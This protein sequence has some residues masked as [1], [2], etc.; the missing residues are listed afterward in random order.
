MK[1]KKGKYR[2]YK[3][4]FYEVID[5]VMHSEDES[6][7]VLYRPLYETKVKQ[8]YNIDL[9]VRPHAMFVEKVMTEAGEVFR[10]E[11]AGPMA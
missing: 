7:L 9:W 4:P 3:G 5:V 6:I 8:D 1:I 2:H 10:F 11:Y